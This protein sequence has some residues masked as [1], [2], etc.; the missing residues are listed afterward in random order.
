[1]TIGNIVSRN[2]NRFPD[3]E[4]LVYKDTRTTWA[5]LDRRVNRLANAFLS[6]GLAKGDKVA[7]LSENVP[8]MVEANYALEDYEVRRG[9]VLTCQSY[10]LTDRVVVDYDQ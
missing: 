5:E 10:P 9:Y 4:A 7:M 2:A 3:R 6:L 1:M 8:A